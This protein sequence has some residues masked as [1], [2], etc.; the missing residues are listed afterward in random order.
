MSENGG[1]A[2]LE[3]K[4]SEQDEEARRRFEAREYAL[5]QSVRSTLGTRDGDP[6]R[7]YLEAVVDAGSYQVGWALDAVAFNEGKRNLARM[8]L[9]MLED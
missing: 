6:L 4:P 1:W 7:E 2:M 8:L 3:A 5:R 9:K